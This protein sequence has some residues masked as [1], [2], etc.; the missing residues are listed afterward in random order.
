MKIRLVLF[1]TIVIIAL[2]SCN[3]GHSGSNTG[4]ENTLEKV[5][6]TNEIHVGY[7]IYEPT[8]MKDPQTDSLKGVFVDMMNEIAKS[9]SSNTKVVFHETSLADFAVGLNSY[10]F[11]LS[12]AATFATPQRAQAASFTH[13]IFYC[14]Y[15]GVTLKENAAKYTTW[16]AIDQPNVKISVLQ[17][18]AIADL[19]K[20][21]FK[22]KTNVDT[23]PGKDVTIPL[24]AVS[25]KKSDVGLMN[26]ITVHTF[27]REHPE[28]VEVMHDQPLATTYFS[29]AV[30][31]NDLIW[32]NYI[33]TCIDY[34]LNSGAMERY[35]RKYGI[36]LMHVRQD[37]Y[38][39]IS[40]K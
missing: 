3:G 4:L 25:S 32:L 17:G 27:L 14:G 30:R 5:I 38:F 8:V 31:H 19:V 18:S 34:L 7:V 39:P 23:Y 16:E 12:I 9:I 28:L 21:D 36:P 40:E 20:V 1:A 33:N 29:W 2:S 15:T 24:A 11:D 22:S 13:P 26:Q 37:Y 6:R 35:E 10:K